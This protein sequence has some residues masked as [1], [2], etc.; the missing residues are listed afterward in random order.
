MPSTER[1]LN[2]W[3]LFG[4]AFT[5]FLFLPGC[6]STPIEIP[7]S[8][9][10]E[11]GAREVF[12]R[13]QPVMGTRFE[14]QVVHDDAAAAA[15]ALDA[16]FAEVARVEDLISEWR[17]SSELSDLNRRGAAGPVAVGPELFEVIQRGVEF[18]E[19]TGGAFDITF[20]ACG[21]LWSVGQERIPSQ[22]EVEA[23]IPRIDYSAIDVD[24]EG[25]TIA[26]GQTHTQIGLGGI[27]KGYGVDKAA[28][29]LMAMG[30]EDFV[31]NGGGDIRVGG[32]RIDRPW[33]MGIV[34][35]REDDALLGTIALSRGALVSS[36]DYERFFFYQGQR[37]HH[38][39]DP[40]TARPAT[41]SVAVTVI[42]EDATTAD[43]LATGIFVMGPGAGIELIDSLDGVE[44]LIVAPDLS[45]HRSRNFESYLQGQR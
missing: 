17:D 42:A 10:A 27:G 43:A 11:K 21:H 38:I 24:D 34:H 37:I 7:E 28:E 8:S 15:R 29:V 36:G 39:I 9:A 3:L 1:L 32:Q 6:W 25:Q 13:V 12:R 35:P 18:S 26:F 44:A 40:L 2:L 14:I 16:A 19:M 5:L 30:I 31:V 23:C 4:L 33:L 45:L 41:R 20:A 22:E